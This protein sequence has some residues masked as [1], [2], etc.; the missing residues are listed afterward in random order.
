[1]VRQKSSARE[2]VVMGLMTLDFLR[3]I[4]Q[5]SRDQFRGVPSYRTF[6]SDYG[7][8]QA[9]HVAARASTSND[10]IDLEDQ[11]SIDSSE[12]SNEA[13]N[14]FRTSRSIW[15]SRFRQLVG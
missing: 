14:D 2:P 8:R 1:M 4:G 12:S 9:R 5:T 11:R 13:S 15:I 6:T 10:S 3:Q 7:K